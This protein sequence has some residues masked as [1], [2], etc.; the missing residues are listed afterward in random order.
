MSD[1]EGNY[2][3]FCNEIKSVSRKYLYSKSIDPDSNRKYFTFIRYCDDCGIDEEQ[4]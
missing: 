1:S 4:R 3:A 2:C